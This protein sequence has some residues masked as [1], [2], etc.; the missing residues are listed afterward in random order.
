MLLFLFA[1][2]QVYLYYTV[3]NKLVFDKIYKRLMLY[4][5]NLKEDLK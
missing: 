3:D 1:F 2:I 5:N 4:Y